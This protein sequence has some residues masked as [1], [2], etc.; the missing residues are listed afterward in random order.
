VN[1]L[2]QALKKYPKFQERAAIDP[3]VDLDAVPDEIRTGV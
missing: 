3:L 2:N 1:N